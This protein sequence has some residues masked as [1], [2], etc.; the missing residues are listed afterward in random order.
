MEIVGFGWQ[1]FRDVCLPIVVL[2]AFGII[3]D[4][5]FQLNLNTLVQLN[6]HVFVPGFIFVKVME[7]GSQPSLFPPAQIIGFTLSVIAATYVIGVILSR[8]LKWDSKLSRSFFLSTMFYN[9]GN[10]GIPMMALAYP[11]SGPS[12][13]VYVLLTMNLSTFTLGMIIASGGKK[14][15]FLDILKGLLRLTPVYAISLGIFC[16]NMNIPVTEWKFVWV[17]L[18]YLDDGLVAVA[19]VTLGV[20]L[21]QTRPPK[22]NKPLSLGLIV[23][24]IGGPAIAY[25]LTLIWGIHGVSAAVLVL[26]AAAPTAIN[27]ALLAHHLNAD[28]RFASAVVFYSTCIAI[29]SVTLILTI[30][31]VFQNG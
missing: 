15:S 22:L 30:Q 6:I 1:L 4:K 10:W 19:L 23:R 2:A 5:K 13:H 21:S 7:S 29:F 14:N 12:I 9:C 25:G 20:Q 26:G 31:R 16:K 11:D 27:T 24:L 17:P 3:L 28:S 8:C 18:K